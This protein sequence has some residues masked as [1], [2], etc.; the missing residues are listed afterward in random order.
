VARILIADDDSFTSHTLAD[1]LRRANFDVEIATTAAGACDVAEIMLPDL[2]IVDLMT[3]RPD[4]VALCRGLKAA[5]LDT[6][7]VFF[8]TRDT[9]EDRVRG[10][11]AGADG[12]EAKTAHPAHPAHLIAPFRENAA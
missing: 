9:V 11:G 1:T 6:P 2:I 3:S 8:T 4:G 5:G 10:L 12:Y 7:I